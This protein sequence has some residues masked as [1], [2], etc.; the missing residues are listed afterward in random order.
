VL[1]R[2][3][4][5]SHAPPRVRK[6]N[7]GIALP[8]GAG[9]R[10]G[11][12]PA[13]TRTDPA[14]GQVAAQWPETSRQDA[15]GPNWPLV[16]LFFLALA[17]VQTFPLVLHMSTHTIGWPVDSYQKW[18]ELAWMKHSL[19][20]LSNP[21]HTGVLNYPQGSDLYLDTLV[22]VNGV[23]A[24]PLE[25]ITGN[26]LLSWNILALLFIA[27]SGAGAYALCYHVTKERWAALFGGFLFAFSP[28]VM[29]QFNASH[30][31]ISATW[32]IPFF[33]LC[34]LRF[35]ERRSKKDLALV[36]VLGAVITWNW[37][38]FAVDAGLFALL[39]FT[40]WAIV[41]ARRG[42]RA[43]I[44]P[45]VRSLFP[46]LVLWAVLTAPILI[47]T[48]IAIE[49]G[50]YTVRLSDT[51]EA[52]N[53]SPDLA[54]YLLPSALWGPGEHPGAFREEYGGARAGTTETTMFLGLS[55][56]FFAAV[57]IAYRRKSP[58]RTSVRFWSLIFG[59]FA[60]MALGP[61][62]HAFSINVPGFLPFRLL[63]E[64]PLIGER[65]VPGRMI[66]VGTLALGVLGTIGVSTMAKRSTLKHAAPLFAC[67]AVAVLL[68][69]YWS[70][71]V[72]LASYNVPQ[73]Y[74]DIGNEDGQ[75]SVL[76]LPLGRTTGNTQQGDLVGASMSD[77]AQAIHG[78]AAI[79]G[80]LSRMPDEDL[81]WLPQ[82]PGLGYL[83]CLACPGYPR[84]I[85]LDA[86]R[87]RALF[88]DLKI[89]YVVVNLVTF[90]GLA[91]T[92]TR[93]GTAA[94]AE[95][96]LENELGYEKIASGD[97]WLAYRNPA[98]N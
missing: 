4:F 8:T 82:Q 63:Q 69:E 5:C 56:L 11:L 95:A 50:D 13:D 1:S 77:Y 24:L 41:K 15:P 25:L 86:E 74:K 97:G 88:I 75:F 20:G 61:Y 83:A 3:T 44:L 71:P 51:N 7:A 49:S 34:L 32:P 81:R 37:F 21:F 60:V 29:M 93:Q 18:W 28:T 42:E 92:L 23:M 47:P 79:G 2:L 65:R 85:D 57:A 58:L 80:Y 27:L 52:D 84:D 53:W 9:V 89:K 55:P 91:T 59:F 22:P 64:V 66:I 10:Q 46:G 17:V 54:S 43:V 26:L 35:F 14:E 68:M 30:F 96:Y 36:A 33:V 78:K 98:V 76:D 12:P 70:P 73:I 38:E 62:L 19:L 45:M 31:N 16:F 72:S 90:E 48:A 87:V 94:E 67:L 40:F 39:L 6:E